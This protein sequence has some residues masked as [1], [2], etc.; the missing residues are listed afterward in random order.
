MDAEP[1]D[2][3]QVVTQRARVLVARWSRTLREYLQ[4]VDMLGLAPG[5]EPLFKTEITMQRLREW[6]GPT[7]GE[8]K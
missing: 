2:S 8:P 4:F 1:D 5:A 6:G 3:N 7:K